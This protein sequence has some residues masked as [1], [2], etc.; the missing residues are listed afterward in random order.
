[1][2]ISRAARAAVS[3][4]RAIA[5]EAGD[6]VVAPT[7]PATRWF[8]EI[9]EGCG[10]FEWITLAYFAWLEAIVLVCHRN[11]PHAGRYFAIHL[12]IAAAIGCLVGGAA[13]SRS[14]VIRFA[15]HWY[16]LP[17]YIFCFEEL[18]GLVHA[19]FPGWFD[20][21]LVAFDYSIA[22]V[23][24]SVWLA[25]FASPALNDFMQF[26]YMTYF[27]E[28]VVLP[29]ILYARRERLAFW[30]VMV[31]TAIANYSIYAI[32]IVL[33]VESPY[34]SLARLQTKPLAG[35]GC[36]A[37]IDLIERF[38]RVHGAAFPSAHVAGSMVAVLAAWR[39]R[40]WLFWVCV[41]FFACMCVATVYGR[42]HY[43]ADV[44]AGFAV[45]AIG[46]AAGSKLMGRVARCRI[47]GVFVATGAGT[48]EAE[49]PETGLRGRCRATTKS[50]TCCR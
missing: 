49:K 17:L 8:D 42:Y 14:E 28:L 22:N 11:I 35:G 44:L 20:P 43:V 15:R 39:Y 6:S 48:S 19:I 2:R 7:P 21:W 37:L 41:P 10:A 9:R 4:G 26:A 33:P 45:G 18:Q 32:A 40:R 23:H 47:A 25:R 12:L 31:S 46:L 27:L 5:W 13:R 34:Y 50:T 1:M 16:P 24:P 29:A 30:T 38:G 36:T 3:G